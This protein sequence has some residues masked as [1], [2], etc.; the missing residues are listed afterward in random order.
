MKVYGKCTKC[1][2]EIF[3]RTFEQTRL[4]LARN[5][6]N[7]IKIICKNCGNDNQIHVNDL[8]ARES[9]IALIIA[10]II[11]L[12][13]TPTAFFLTSEAIARTTNHYYIYYIGGVLLV[14]SIIYILV[15][16]QERLRV[17]A[18]N[19]LKLSRKS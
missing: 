16:K 4:D 1:R 9:K 13:G 11:F 14:P 2:S 5:K 10:L 18:F 17:N 7:L 15:E 12:I 8:K 3:L 19:R 6:G